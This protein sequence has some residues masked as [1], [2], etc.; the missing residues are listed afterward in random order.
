[1]FC[2]L[3]ADSGK[4]KGESGGLAPAEAFV[5]R[6]LFFFLSITGLVCDRGRG[7]R[8]RRDWRVVGMGGSG[9]FQRQWD[10]QRARKQ[11]VVDVIGVTCGNLKD[12]EEESNQGW[13]QR[14]T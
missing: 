12:S 4:Y 5:L 11:H 8:L 10:R 9:V 14:M 13:T 7:L 3:H 1:M 6:E 2:A